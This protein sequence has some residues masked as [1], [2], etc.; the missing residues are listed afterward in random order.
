MFNVLG[1]IGV[2]PHT[3][4][5]AAIGI[6]VVISGYGRIAYWN[7]WKRLWSMPSPREMTSWPKRT[8]FLRKAFDDQK[9]ELKIAEHKTEELQLEL[10]ACLQENAALRVEM[11]D[12]RIRLHRARLLRSKIT[13]FFIILNIYLLYAAFFK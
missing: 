8:L 5:S 2:P 3:S 13:R 9:Q 10:D 12:I 1:H 11:E 6:V 4:F 7:I